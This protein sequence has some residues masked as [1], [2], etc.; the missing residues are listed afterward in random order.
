MIRASMRLA[1]SLAVA[2]VS[3]SPVLGA[4]GASTPLNFAPRISHDQL[5]NWAGY[6][7]EG[8]THEFSSATATWTEPKVDCL[9]NQDLY[10]PWVGI[11]GD[12]SSTVEQTG[13]QT[14]CKGGQPKVKAW[15]EMFP[16]NPV[17]FN[18]PAAIGD[19]F[20]ATVTYSGG[21]FTLTI[22]DTT[23]GWT[24]T[25]HKTLN[26]AKRLSAE[27]VI[28]APGGFPNIP[29]G[30]QFTGVKFNGQDLSTFHPVASA[31][32]GAGNTIYKPGAIT[33]GDDFSVLP[34]T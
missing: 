22:S 5:S 31:S 3:L 13:A 21:Q 25:V 18:N 6:I 7:A 26:S 19:I 14:S 23:Q 32:A 29:S 20:H 27:A 24:Q 10:A 33:N 28:E 4:A 34:K 2:T 11:D 30:V 1:A 8:T 12:G 15:Y 9:K 16:A 17:Y